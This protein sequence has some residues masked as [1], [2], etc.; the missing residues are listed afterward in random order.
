MFSKVLFSTPGLGI[1]VFLVVGTLGCCCF[2]LF[3]LV[4]VVRDFITMD[5]LFGICGAFVLLVEGIFTILLFGYDLLS[6]DSSL[7]S[8]FRFIVGLFCLFRWSVL[9]I[10][11]GCSFSMCA[12]FPGSNVS[13]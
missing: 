10:I 4:S 12:R 13:W 9:V 7:L 5:G 3:L 8:I 6:G 1:V 2:A 11:I